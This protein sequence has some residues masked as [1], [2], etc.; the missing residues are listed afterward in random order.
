MAEVQHNSDVI[1][2][3]PQFVVWPGTDWR[4]SWDSSL[5]PLEYY[6]NLKY[7]TTAS[8]QIN[9]CSPF[10]PQR[11]AGL[12]LLTAIQFQQYHDQK[13]RTGMCSTECPKSP[14]TGSHESANPLQ[15]TC[16]EKFKTT[17]NFVCKH[18]SREG[19]THWT[20][21]VNIFVDKSIPPYASKLFGHAAYWPLLRP[22]T[23]R[24]ERA[25]NGKSR[26]HRKPKNQPLI[27][28]R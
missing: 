3:T 17:W 19:W 25:D 1:R 16:R 24:V 18:V 20:S 10:M 2:R 22:N 28:L 9:T 8:F 6:S 27:T 4:F 23:N 13:R 14:T 15:E 7:A 26:G 11:V 5:S 21:F 12:F